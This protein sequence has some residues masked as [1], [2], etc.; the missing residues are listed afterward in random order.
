MRLQA[1]FALCLLAAAAVQCAAQT[2]T[3]PPPAADDSGGIA[4]QD[5]VCYIA[6]GVA[7]VAIGVVIQR[8][9]S[10]WRRSHMDG[11]VGF[12]AAGLL[13]S[14]ETDETTTRNWKIDYGDLEIGALLGQGSIGRV[15]AGKWR[16][17][18]VAVKEVQHTASESEIVAELSLLIRVRHP[19]L[20][21]FMGLAMP[22]PDKLCLVSEHMARG[23]LYTVLHDKTLKLD[24]RRRLLMALD[25]ARAMNYLHC[26]RPPILHG[27]LNSINL[28]V[29][30]ELV[31]KASDYAV[32]TIR[33]RAKRSG[34]YTQPLWVAPEV[35]RS[36]RK[37]SKAS[38]VYSF[39]IVLWEILT[40]RTPYQGMI[41]VP[42]G[43]GAGAAHI[44]AIADIVAGMRPLLPQGTPAKYASLVTRCWSADPSLRPDFQTIV[45]ELS[46][47][48]R[49]KHQ[50]IEANN[51][52]LKKNQTELEEITIAGAGGKGGTSNGGKGSSAAAAADD[53]DD[54][55][56]DGP[57][58]LSAL[59]SAPS[60]SSSSSS[61]RNWLVSSS[62]IS[63]ESLIG[64]GSFGEVWLANWRGKKVAVKK[65]Q[66]GPVTGV[67]KGNAALL[68][69]GAPGARQ[70]HKALLRDFVREINLMCSLRHSS[71]VLFMG[72]CI[73]KGESSL[74]LVMEYAEKKDLFALLQDKSIPIDYNLILKILI[75]VAEGV[76]YLHL[77]KPNPIIHRDLKS[78]NILI[79]ANFEAKISDFGLT[80]FKPDGSLAAPGVD[81]AQLQLG[82]PFWQSPEAM[83]R[84]EYSESSDTYAFG[85]VIFELFTREIPFRNLNP[86]QAALAVIAEDKRPHIPAFVPPKFGALMQACWLR[87]PHQR[88]SM[89]E[90]LSALSILKNEGLPRI[91]L[92]M[93]L[94]HVALYRKRTLVFAYKSKDSV[95]VY[96]PWGTGEG[97]KGD[98]VLVGPGDDVYTYVFSFFF[99]SKTKT[100]N[101][102][103]EERC[104]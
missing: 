60:S 78:A 19:N 69:G 67:L 65:M 16:G 98:W 79:D 35:L 102:K 32:D 62:E 13:G 76:Q 33:Q 85:M 5:L 22:T 18:L 11:G 42:A 15:Y 100:H 75:A 55:D 71:I 26:S 40:R 94:S 64:R 49:E 84:G 103:Q 29:D 48:E 31:T 77:H 1:V 81:N 80:D 86:H 38:D 36:A 87:D 90:I 41:K 74:A 50:Q 61:C 44:K 24:W 51:T 82:T 104:Q 23:N 101:K 52:W 9:Y 14:N 91:E 2:S 93:Q 10:L 46:E 30:K 21:L 63:Y 45:D 34:V 39:G 83:E 72:A 73:E 68:A 17:L 6:I 95:I 96:K 25:A 70:A 59:L 12:T 28:L 27:H 7:A 57:D 88:P 97:K 20:C 43:A 92:S 58:T 47:M 89:A 3:G 66:Q 37:P 53:A 8:V 4:W 54:D 56:D 99:F